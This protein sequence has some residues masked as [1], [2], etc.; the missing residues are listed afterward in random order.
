MVHWLNQKPFYLTEYYGPVLLIWQPHTGFI[1]INKQKMLFA[2]LYI[3][4]TKQKEMS[5][6]TPCEQI[7]RAWNLNVSLHQLMRDI[8]YNPG[9]G[10][11]WT[12][13]NLHTQYT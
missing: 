8:Q 2:L 1:P 13:E 7:T 10:I 11:R 4:T 9:N 3:L 12:N 5:L 6:F